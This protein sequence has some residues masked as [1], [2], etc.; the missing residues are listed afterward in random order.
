[1]KFKKVFNT[2]IVIGGILVSNIIAMGEEISNSTL[3]EASRSK[4]LFF[5]NT[6]LSDTKNSGKGTSINWLSEPKRP[7]VGQKY[8]PLFT[9][10]G[11][12]IYGLDFIPTISKQTYDLIDHS[13]GVIYNNIIKNAKPLE[14]GE[15]SYYVGVDGSAFSDDP[16][17]N[18]LG[19]GTEIT[20]AYFGLDYK[21]HEQLRLGGVFNVGQ[22]KYNYDDSN[23]SR[24]DTFFQGSFYLDH[25]TVENLRFISMIYFGKTNSD[26]KRYYSATLYNG[27]K[28]GVSVNENATSDMENYYFGINNNISKRYDIDKFK[29]SF[30]YAP[31]FQFNAA[32]LM[33]DSIN[34]STT[35]SDFNG[36]SIESEDSY[37]VNSSV[38]IAIGKDFLLKNNRK[39]NLEFGVDLL[40]EFGDPY[41]ELTNK[42]NFNDRAPISGFP[43]KKGEPIGKTN[44]IKGYES[45]YIAIAT[46]I[47]GYY[48]M[49]DNFSFYGGINYNFGENE[50][51][52]YGNL[53]INYTF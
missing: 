27:N 2:V 48:E 10:G 51:N 13:N 47:I 3:E 34:E 28:P 29:T 11:D 37:S 31:R 17:D 16:Y 21:I 5:S 44:T 45:D 30:Y 32:Y 25:K 6:K 9:D 35:S 15:H 42:T 41:S 22:S 18:V 38:G 39:F 52:I 8:D 4:I 40:V 14:K 43:P 7:L 23:S 33:Q 12:A 49:N 19:Y 36:L 53:G 46:S 20:S 1:M 26:L 50:K 24:E